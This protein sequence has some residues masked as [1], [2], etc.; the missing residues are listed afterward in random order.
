VNR[1]GGGGGG[2]LG[3]SGASGGSGIVVIR[4]LDGYPAATVTGSPTYVVS[5]GYRTYTFTGTGTIT[6]N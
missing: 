4:F 6:F 3:G 1:G 2:K 5:G